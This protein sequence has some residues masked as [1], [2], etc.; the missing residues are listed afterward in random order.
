MTDKKHG[1]KRNGSGRK[2]LKYEEKKIRITIW[3]KGV[4]INKAGGKKAAK[5]LALNAIEQC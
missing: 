2:K 4:F 1:G 5:E 3:P